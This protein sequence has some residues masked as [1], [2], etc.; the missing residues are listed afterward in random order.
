MFIRKHSFFYSAVEL[1]ESAAAPPPCFATGKTGFPGHISSQYIIWKHQ[2][3]GDKFI[4]SVS[5]WSELPTLPAEK[6][7]QRSRDLIHRFS[8]A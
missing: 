7:F 1:H 6:Y 5:N 3:F 4:K 2:L 8:A